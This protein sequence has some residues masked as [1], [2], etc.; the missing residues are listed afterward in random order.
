[1]NP[2]TNI[3]GGRGATIFLIEMRGGGNEGSKN[4]KT[5]ALKTYSNIINFTF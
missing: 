1:M 5:T 4:L 2:I 3:R